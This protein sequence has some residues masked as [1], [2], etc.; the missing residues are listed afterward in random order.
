MRKLQGLNGRV[1]ER[2]QRCVLTA[3]SA[4]SPSLALYQLS[5]VQRNRSSL[6]RIARV[7]RVVRA[8]MGVTPLALLRGKR[9][10]YSACVD[11][12]KCATSSRTRSTRAG[13]ICAGFRGSPDQCIQ[14]QRGSLMQAGPQS[15]SAPPSGTTTFELG[16]CNIY[17]IKKKIKCTQ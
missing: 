9:T 7:C 14:H 5:F 8:E 6:R 10:V 11:S 13:N 2:T 12:V 15:P 16:V 4:L 3:S 1:V 17:K